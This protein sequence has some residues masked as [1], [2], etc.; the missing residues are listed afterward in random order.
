MSTCT[1][2]ARTRPTSTRKRIRRENEDDN[3]EH[4][5]DDNDDDNDDDDDDNNFVLKEFSDYG[6][7]Q[8]PDRRHYAP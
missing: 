5:D 6:G 3:G 8:M 1:T 7:R 4:G 2:R